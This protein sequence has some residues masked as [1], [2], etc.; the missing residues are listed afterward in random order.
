MPGGISAVRAARA[1]DAAVVGAAMLPAARDVDHDRR[2]RDLRKDGKVTAIL[3][4][5]YPVR[6][7]NNDIGPDEPHL[8]DAD[9]LRD[10]TPSPGTWRW[11]E[12]R[13]RCQPRRQLRR[14][15][16]A[17]SPVPD[18]LSGRCCCESNWH[19]ASAA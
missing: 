9:G 7:W 2:L 1:G 15:D 18:R 17:S 16:M 6:F 14:D 19:P 10:L 5:D 13:F 11:L 8:L 3:H 4:T 12:S